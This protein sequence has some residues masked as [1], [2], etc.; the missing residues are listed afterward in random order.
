MDAKLPSFNKLRLDGLRVCAPGP[1]ATINN[2][3]RQGGGGGSLLEFEANFE[4]S[5]TD[6][7]IKPCVH[8]KTMIVDARAPR[9]TGTRSNCARKPSRR[10]QPR[11]PAPVQTTMITARNGCL[12]ARALAARAGYEYIFPRGSSGVLGARPTALQLFAHPFTRAP[13]RRWDASNDVPAGGGGGGGAQKKTFTMTSSCTLVH[14][15]CS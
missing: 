4:S 9:C 7:T 5:G 12:T 6:T 11:P 14:T 15:A 13:A 10:R 1:F 8:R 2:Y 3:T